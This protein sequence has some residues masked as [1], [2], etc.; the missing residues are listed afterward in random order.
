MARNQDD[1]ERIWLSFIGL[2]RLFGGLPPVPRPEF[3]TP[4][5]R[6][7]GSQGRRPRNIAPPASSSAAVTHGLH[8]LR[9]P[10]AI[11]L[12]VRARWQ[13]RES[14]LPRSG[15]RSV[16]PAVSISERGGGATRLPG[17]TS[18]SRTAARGSL[19][20][21]LRS[22]LFWGLRPRARLHTSGLQLRFE[23]GI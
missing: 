16:A 21:K 7:F 20:S 3:G 4:R 2:H 22:I 1:I 10:R 8:R 23:R 9:R 19:R 11:C 15:N 5:F 18:G 17:L 14:Q 13:A 6:D 12:P